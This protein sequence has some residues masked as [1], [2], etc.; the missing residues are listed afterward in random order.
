MGQILNKYKESLKEITSPK[1]E[2][3]IDLKNTRTNQSTNKQ[4]ET[5]YLNPLAYK[6]NNKNYHF[7]LIFKSM[8]Q[9]LK[10]ILIYGNHNIYKCI[11]YN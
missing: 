10:L 2:Q 5:I 4:E 8:K 1:N 7:Y 9:K 6:S 11:K 3:K